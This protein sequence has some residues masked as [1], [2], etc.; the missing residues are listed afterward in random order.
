MNASPS[1][2]PRR[3][4]ALLALATVAVPSA[5]D[6][7]ADRPQS[8]V[9][10]VPKRNE[11]AAPAASGVP[12]RAGI[13]AL[14]PGATLPTAAGQSIY[15]PITTRVAADDGR[16]IRLVVNV[17][18]RNADETRP[19]LV[20]LLRHRDADGKT[21]RDYLRAP[22]RLAP[23]ATLDVVLKDPEGPGPATSVRV[24]WVADRPVT[25]PIVGA[26]MIGTVGSQGISFTEHGQVIE[27]RQHPGLAPR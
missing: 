8:Q 4:L 16:P 17:A 1:P 12:A 14:E 2:S 26:V 13:S 7:Q 15:L 6:Q 22:V 23:K 27:D 24:E 10:A 9:A 21:V 3:C 20:T 18:V 5:C 11:K 19:I 25:P